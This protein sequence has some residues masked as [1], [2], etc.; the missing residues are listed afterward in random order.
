MKRIVTPDT[1]KDWND[2][3]RDIPKQ[4]E[5]EQETKTKEVN[6]VA[7]IIT[8]GNKM[9]NNATDNRDKSLIS[10]QLADFSVCRKCLKNRVS[11]IMPTK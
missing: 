1:Y 10:M 6:S 9:W 8:Y 2:M 5:V 11:I 7:D 3:L 4:I